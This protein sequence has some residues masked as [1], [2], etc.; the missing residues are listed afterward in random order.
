M[1][2]VL[3]IGC[4]GAGKSTFSRRLSAKTGLP[5]HYL[6]MIWHKPDRTNISQEEFDERL[7]S[8][9]RF[10]EWIIDGNYLRTL[11]R[12]LQECDTVFFFDIPLDDC[13]KGVTD[14]LGKPREDMPWVDT[15]LDENFHQWILNFPNGQR[16][17]IVRLLNTFDGK[18]L[19]FKSRE[20]ANDHLDSLND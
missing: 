3:V 20:E 16:P 18:V 11:P 13:L 6:D 14:R 4:P 8:I 15:E 17:E 10:D 9:L 19:H 1:K 5:I 7:E 12:R 2:R